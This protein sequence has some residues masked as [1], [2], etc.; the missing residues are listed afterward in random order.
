MF[1]LLTVKQWVKTEICCRYYFWFH[2]HTRNCI[3]G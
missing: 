3:V 1:H 2:L